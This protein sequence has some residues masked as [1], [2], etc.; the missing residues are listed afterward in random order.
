MS[1]KFLTYDE[2]IDKL[3]SKGIIINDKDFA[4]K[5]LKETSYFSLVSGYKDAFRDKKTK[6]YN[7]N[8]KFEDI[9]YLYK[10]DEEL[11]NLFLKYILK[12]E[13]SLKSHYSYF[14]CEKFGEE[15][16]EYLN[17]NNFN[18][19][20]YQNEINELIKILDEYTKSNKYD[21]ITYNR[22]TYSN[23]PFWILTNCLTFGNLSKMYEYSNINIKIDIAKEFNIQNSQLESM[24]KIITKFRNVC[25]HNQRLYNYKTKNFNN[26]KNSIKDLPI[27]KTKNLNNMGKND[28]FGICLC[29]KYLLNEIDF[30]IF[31]EALNDIL[32]NYKTN[33]SNLLKI[34]KCMGFPQDWYDWLE[35]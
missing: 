6:I 7:K 12:I 23:I 8:V 13:K 29:F 26:K 27:H 25:A 28:L 21:Y 33:C 11:R 32:I 22:D 10:L 17:V 3:T 31:L 19:Q 9:Y 34:L 16:K 1:K 20:N 35:Q 15:Q 18:Y 5:C 14:F 2:Q 30:N 24:L 4:I